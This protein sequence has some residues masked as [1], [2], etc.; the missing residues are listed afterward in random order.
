M[1]K[2]WNI[3]KMNRHDSSGELNNGIKTELQ[4]LPTEALN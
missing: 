2:I 1:G 4:S 3:F